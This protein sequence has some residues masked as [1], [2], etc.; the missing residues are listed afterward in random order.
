PEDAERYEN[1]AQ[2]EELLFGP[3]GDMPILPIYFYTNVSLQ[4]ESIKETFNQNLLDQ[5]DLT[6][7]VEGDDS[8]DEDA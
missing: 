6:K 7:V 2:M 4:R 8:G 3:E 5:I 1:Y